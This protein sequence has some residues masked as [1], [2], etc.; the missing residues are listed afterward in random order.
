MKKTGLAV[1]LML[2]VLL[3]G[4]CGLRTVKEMYALPKRSQE[5]SQLQAAVDN[6]MVGLTYCAP[7]SGDNQQTVQIADLDGDG[8][9]EFLVFAQ[10]NVDKSLNILVFAQ[11]S[12]GT[13][14]LIDT[15]TSNG[16]AFEQVEYEQLDDNPGC[17]LVVGRQVSDQVLRSVSVYTYRNGAIQQQ[18]LT[19]YSRFLICDLAEDGRKELLVI[20]PG[21][22]MTHRGTA[23]LYSFRNNQP[24]RSREVELS[25]DPSNI[26]RVTQTRLQDGVPAVFV[27]SAVGDTGVVTDILAIQEGKFT[28]ITFSAEADTSM[29]TLRNHY[30]YA[31]DIDE[32]GILELP[33]VLSLM[34]VPNRGKN[35]QDCLL[36]WYSIDSSGREMDKLYTFHNLSQGW[37][38]ELDSMLA[39]NATVE[40]WDNSYC[41][42]EWDADFDVFN[43]VYNVYIFT[44]TDR[45]EMARAGGR[46]PLYSTESVVYAAKLEA[47]AQTLGITEESL[48]NSFRLIR[49]NRRTGEIQ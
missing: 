17:E 30:V 13:C 20:R 14:H 25:K 6:A 38:M 41:F 15:I 8:V 12:D 35:Q 1:L 26:R 46:F 24:E 32:D 22:A 16:A 23:L 33:G 11:E 21:E 39:T 43:P 19:G 42:Y 44:G 37:Y 48:K 4:G 3:L 5:Y 2:S 29:G 27:A 36:R 47:T 31:E 7:V 34:D 18:L 49:Q 40:Q 28:N 10:D 45:D 9:Q